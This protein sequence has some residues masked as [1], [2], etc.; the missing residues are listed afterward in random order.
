MKMFVHN[1][2]RSALVDS[3]SREYA[4]VHSAV[5]DA[6]REEPWSHPRL[7]IPQVKLWE[8][9]INNSGE[10]TVQRAGSAWQRHRGRE[11]GGAEQEAGS[12]WP[13]HRGRHGGGPGQGA[14]SGWQRD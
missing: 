1:H 10:G 7:E 3:H 6:T 11:K 13:R 9:S 2:V 5:L 14:G 8:N 4:C 12:A